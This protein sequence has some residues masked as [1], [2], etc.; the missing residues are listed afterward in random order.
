MTERRHAGFSLIELMIVVVI[1]AILASIAYPSYV[2][3]VRKG[4]RSD[5]KIGLQQLAQRQESYYT[6]NY[7]YAST[8]AQLGYAASG[9]KLDSPEREYEL[10]LS[11]VTPGGCGG[12]A[13]DACSGFTVKAEPRTGGSQTGDAE[14]SQFTLDHM[15]RRAA[16]GTGCWN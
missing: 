3:Q 12:T 4:K 15:G 5:A 6:R 1:V 10:S 14:C 16:S 11:G 2:Q 8:L 13:A 7:S 9:G